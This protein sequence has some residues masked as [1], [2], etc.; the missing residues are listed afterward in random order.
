[1]SLNLG[2]GENIERY[3][4]T[5]YSLHDTYSTML[6]RGAVQERLFP[7]TINGRMDGVP[8]FFNQEEWELIKKKS[9]RK[10]IASQQLQ[11]PL[12]DEDARFQPTWLKSY[13]IRPAL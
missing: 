2:G 13:E 8:V 12:A 9:S 4:G 6:H 11:N 5:R 1:M 3:I 7:A 10:T